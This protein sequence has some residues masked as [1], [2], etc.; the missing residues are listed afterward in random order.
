MRGIS[1][2]EKEGKLGAKTCASVG[3]KRGGEING[4]K[5]G[6]EGDHQ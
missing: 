4:R 1:Y 3:K 2:L 6:Q 5:E